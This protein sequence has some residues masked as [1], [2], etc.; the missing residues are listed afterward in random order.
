MNNDKKA[1]L[2]AM[3]TGEKADRVPMMLW[4]H[5]PGDDLRPT[6]Y[7]WAVAWFQYQWDCDVVRIAPHNL[8]TVLD[9]GL[10]AHWDGNPWGHYQ[11][12]KPVI[13]RSLDWTELRRLDV[14][15][16]FFGQQRAALAELNDLLPPDT[17]R[18]LSLPSPLTQAAY[19]AGQ[20]R[21]LRDMRTHPDR[22]KTGLNVITDNI[23]RFMDSLHGSTLDGLAYEVTLASYHLMNADEFAAF[24]RPYD[25]K[26]LGAVPER[27]WLNLV[28]LT[29]DAPMVRHVADYPAQILAWPDRADD[30]SLDKG[31]SV[32]GGVVCGGM[33]DLAESMPGE[34]R[35]W[36]Y[37]AVD[38]TFGRHFLLASAGPLSMTTPLANIRA[39]SNAIEE[40]ATRL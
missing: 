2:Q 1:R 19:L 37:Q 29:G 3:L 38:A 21:L 33:G 14:Q 8:Y 35:N 22:L 34:I 5:F 11:S 13:T 10:Q 28:H 40:V 15:R 26:L 16:G 18:I 31:K 9:Y 36:V 32:F 25:L 39:V 27:W 7:A 20:D 24:G 4:R 23:L 12:V 30:F 6:D 17:P